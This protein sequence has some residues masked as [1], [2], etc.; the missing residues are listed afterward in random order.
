MLLIKLIKFCIVGFSGL[1]LDFVTTWILKEK[2]KINKY[3]SNSIGFLIA[4]TSNYIINRVWT[5]NS[6]NSNLIEE[7]SI[8]IFISSIGL[9]INNTI[10]F[11]THDKLYFKF[12]TA[13]VIAIIV[14][15]I[16]NFTGNYF[17]TFST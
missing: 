6:L 2:I 12:Y 7:Y 11:I 8:F 1:I 15:T 3:L 5:F 14:T 17:Y 4:A 10:L 9:L 16:W 13:K